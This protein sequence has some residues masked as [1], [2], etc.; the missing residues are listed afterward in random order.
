MAAHINSENKLFNMRQ[1][2]K[3]ERAGAYCLSKLL[4]CAA[5]CLVPDKTA[6]MH[7]TDSL[8]RIRESS[9]APV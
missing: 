2:R 1:R 5:S 6:A 8:L 3:K 9:I 4:C 7:A